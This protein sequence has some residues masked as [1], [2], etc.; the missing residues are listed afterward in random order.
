MQGSAEADAPGRPPRKP[1]PS[2]QAAP[3]G[4]ALARKPGAGGGTV[5][6]RPSL[7]AGVGW[8]QAA[9]DGSQGQTSPSA[10]P[11]RARGWWL[12]AGDVGPTGLAGAAGKEQCVNNGVGA[13]VKLWG[14][15]VQ[16]NKTGRKAQGQ[17]R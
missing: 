1:G 3:P 8:P 14:A 16:M 4:R 15:L 13:Q 12:L 10:L 9:G 6:W 5:P 7:A 2:R 11:L 17:V